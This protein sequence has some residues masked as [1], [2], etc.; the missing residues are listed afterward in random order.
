MILKVSQRP[1]RPAP[2]DARVTSVERHAQAYV[3]YLRET[4]ALARATIT[5]YLPFIFDFLN[6]RFGDKPVTLSRLCADDVVKF[7]QRQVQRLNLKRAKLMT[8]AL[9][10]FL[11]YARCCGD[12]TLDLAAT[13]PVQ[14]SATAPHL[15]S[16]CKR[17][18]QRGLQV[19]AWSATLQTQVAVR[20]AIFLTTISV[21]LRS[22]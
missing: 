11:R 12:I 15:Y 8:T 9:R 20:V 13:V 4:R 5:N 19:F 2:V 14:P 6:D 22:Y 16:S 21:L 10:S 17:R 18:S 3:K 7:V 1:M